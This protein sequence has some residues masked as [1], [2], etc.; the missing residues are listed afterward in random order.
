MEIYQLK[1]FLQVARYLSFTEAARSLNLTQPAVS[2]KIKSL[3]SNI[4]MPLFSRQGRQVRLTEVGDFLLE[5][6]SDLVKQEE[7]LF[8]KLEDYKNGYRGELRLACSTA[9]SLGFIAN[10]IFHFRTQ[11]PGVNLSLKTYTSSQ[12]LYHALT[13]AEVD[14]AVSEVSFAGSSEVHCEPISSLE[15][16]VVCSPY[17][18]VSRRGWMSLKEALG[19]TWVLNQQDRI[20]QSIFNAR[21]QDIGL[22]VDDIAKVEIVETDYLMKAYLM[23]GEYLGFA[24]KS[25]FN[26]EIQSG[27]LHFISLHEFPLESSIFFSLAAKDLHILRKKET[28]SGQPN[29]TEDPVVKILKLLKEGVSNRQPRRSSHTNTKPAILTMAPP[30]HTTSIR[31]IEKTEALQIRIGIQTRTLPA[32]TGGVV[33]K[34]LGLFEHYLPRTGRYAA[35]QYELQWKDFS[36]GMPIVNGLHSSQLDLGILGDYPMLLS[37]LRNDRL[38]EGEDS[39]VLVGFVAI[40]PNGCRNAVIVPQESNLNQIDDL[41]GQTL[42]IPDGSAA[43]GMVLRVLHQHGLL[44]DVDL[45]PVQHNLEIGRTDRQIAGYAYFSPFHELALERNRFRYLFDGNLSGLPAFYGVVARRGFATEHPELVVSYL[46]GLMAAQH[47]QLTVPSASKKLA[48]WTRNSAR[49][50]DS[51]IGS[52]P[53]RDSQELY[54]PDPYIREDWL[55]EHVSHYQS[56]SG[57]R[58]FS[59]LNLSRWID[60]D[61]MATALRN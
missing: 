58:D 7:L 12:D 1:V 13:S 29:S 44:A 26:S 32:A 28:P 43:H 46:R 59:N 51:I 6:A 14:A 56:A 27:Q 60:T 17:R 24:S 53:E 37:A 38:G 8:Q 48:Q 31:T 20:A 47:W 23:S 61:Y 5:G 41:R 9:I 36:T 2:A 21:L 52:S 30:I 55:L 18:T 42:A 50:I 57:D 15:Y 34:E 22:G 4:G 16:G 54:F 3:E 49:I 10:V 40:N 19:E 11:N 45:F 33:M 35:S 39:T 25:I